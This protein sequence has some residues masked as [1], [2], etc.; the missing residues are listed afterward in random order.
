M[1]RCRSCSDTSISPSY[2]RPPGTRCAGWRSAPCGGTGHGG[3]MRS[4][5]V[6]SEGS[7]ARLLGA[8]P[9]PRL[10]C[11]CPQC[12]SPDPRDARL[13]SSLLLDGRILVDAGPDAYEQLRR[14]GTVPE[15]V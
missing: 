7:G 4:G 15:E 10:G 3:I 5:S 6:R 13:R 8:W 11:D 12:T 14:A 1:L 2:T 9:I